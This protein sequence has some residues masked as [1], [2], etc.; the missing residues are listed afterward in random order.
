MRLGYWYGLISLVLVVLACPVAA[1]SD[2]DAADQELDVSVYDAI[3]P[4]DPAAG[5]FLDVDTAALARLATA[6]YRNGNYEQ[7][8]RLYLAG[9]KQNPADAGEIYNLACCYGLLGEAELA[10][11]YLKRAVSAGYSDLEH[12]Q[13]DGDFDSVREAEAFVA[14]VAELEAAKAEREA[15]LGMQLDIE[16]RA[17]FKCRVR[18]PEGYDP[19]KAY[20]LVVGLHGYGHWPDGFIKVYDRFGDP[21]F[22]FAAPQAPYPFSGGKDIGYSWN[23]WSPHEDHVWPAA[24]AMSREYVRDVVEQLRARYLVSEVYLL[25]FSQ[26]CSL[27]YTA[28]LSDPELVKGI[29]CFGGWLDEDLLTEAML[30]RASGVRVFIV[31]GNQDN[32]VEFE[33]GK[34]ALARLEEL[35]YDVTF[36]EFDGA[37]QVPEEACLAAQEWML[38]PPPQEEAPDGEEVA[39]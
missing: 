21:Q 3:D 18:V 5:E 14:A 27:A 20:P 30:E 34:A 9:L 24:Q 32:V 39:E 28:G 4:L 15:G 6:E 38:N 25:G 8:A 22:I 10:A 17:F 13:W 12:I 37:H 2:D 36:Y 16:S 23:T 11:E 31:H 35:N 26:G 7:A 33:S 19:G 1:C 29:V